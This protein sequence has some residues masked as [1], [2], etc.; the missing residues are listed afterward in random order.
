MSLV[1]KEQKF[2]NKPWQ[3]FTFSQIKC[4]MKCN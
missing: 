1:K 4:K 3:L 2:F